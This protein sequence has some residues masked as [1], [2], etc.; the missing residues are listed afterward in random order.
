MLTATSL[1]GVTHGG[2]ES[3]N[4]ET[5]IIMDTESVVQIVKHPERYLI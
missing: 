5:M 4:K 3:P 1:V 2:V